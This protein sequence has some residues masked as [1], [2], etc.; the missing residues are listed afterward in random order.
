M[1]LTMICEGLAANPPRVTAIDVANFS[2]ILNAAGSN[3][4]ITLSNA[5]GRPIAELAPVIQSAGSRNLELQIDGL[6]ASESQAVEIINSSIGP[7]TSV[8]ISSI[9][10]F[11]QQ[12]I[13]NVVTAAA[14]KKI[15]VKVNCATASEAQAVF[16]AN[17]VR[18]TSIELGFLALNAL[19]SQSIPAVFTAVGS[20]EI[21]AEINALTSTVDQAKNVIANATPATK[22]SLVNAEAL[23]YE[24]VAQIVQTVGAREFGISVNAESM[25]INDLNN[26]AQITNP[27]TSLSLSMAHAIA[28]GNISNLIALSA[29]KKL[30]FSMSGQTSTQDQLR[31]A[32]TNA[33][34]STSTSIDTA[35]AVMLSVML[36]LIS[37]SANK[38]LSLTY[39]GSQ[40]VVTPTDGNY[41]VRALQVAKP[42]T[43]ITVNS[44]GVTNFSLQHTLEIVQA[45]G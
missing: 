42:T 1:K 12:A 44:I 7:N 4:Q 27:N 36:D 19:P 16:I 14:G 5:Q 30:S 2:Q 33:N 26:L 29:G 18:D 45:A 34:G 13:S 17:A 8:E 37:T 32:V 9:N 35:H 15:S 38:D 23:G 11:T 43:S 39:N 3:T 40:L 10:S 20:K 24:G 28:A 6:R 21:S 31:A 25:T 22:L 41:V